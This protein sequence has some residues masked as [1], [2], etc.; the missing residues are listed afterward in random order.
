MYFFVTCPLCNSSNEHNDT[1][2]KDFRYSAEHKCLDCITHDYLRR[3]GSRRCPDCK[4]YYL[5]IYNTSSLW[6]YSFAFHPEQK[7]VLYRAVALSILNIMREKR[8]KLPKE[9]D[10]F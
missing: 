4:R 3:L 9:F 10:H 5:V 2:K 1:A 7:H 6:H 8:V